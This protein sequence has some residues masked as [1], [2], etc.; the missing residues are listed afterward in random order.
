MLKSKDF[1]FKIKIISYSLVNYFLVL[2]I[3]LQT[4]YVFF[5][6]LKYKFAS[7]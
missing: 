1:L 3:G 5:M 4:G 6:Y 2:G 7:T